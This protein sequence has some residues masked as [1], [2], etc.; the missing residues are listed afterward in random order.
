MNT[1]VWWHLTRASAIVAWFMAFGSI[2]LGVLLSTRAM[3]G[4]DRPAWL[5]D[6]HQW[7]GALTCWFTGVHLVTLVADS[8]ITY[9]VADLFVPFSHPYKTTPVAL[10]IVAMYLL[11]AVQGTSLMMKKLPKTLWRR[12]H[13]LSYLMFAL[14]TVHGITA[15]SDTGKP[16]FTGISTMLA[17]VGAAVGGI[18]FVK[19]RWRPASRANRSP[20]ISK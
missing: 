3:K 5:L 19:G 14:I 7:L 12:I 4:I 18:R 6:L 13:M 10:G 1:Q 20:S 16:W 8:Y 9:T 2:L 11:L 15:G 17:M